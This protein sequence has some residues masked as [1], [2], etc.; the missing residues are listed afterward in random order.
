[1]Y[2]VLTSGMKSVI[3]LTQPRSGSSLLAGIL[4]RLGVTM[5]PEEDMIM[6]Q[7]KNKFGS[8]ED[9]AWL[10][11]SHNILYS[12]KRLM[13]Y[14]K[15]FDESD[16]KMEKTVNKYENEIVK[17][18]RKSEKELWGFKEAVII[19][20]LPYF[21]QHFKNPY[22]IVLHRDSESVANSQ[23]RAGK[24]KNWIPEIKMEFSYFTFWKRIGLFLRTLRATFTRG[25]IYRK[26]SFI[27]KV[28]EDGHKRITEFVKDKKY[29]WIELPEIIDY[30]EKTIE[31]I[32]NFLEITP[33]KEQKIDALRF[34]HPEL[35]TSDVNNTNND[36]INKE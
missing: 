1:M 2:N 7:H 5:G 26:K 31:K 30:P 16:G 19:Y 8:Y 3:I 33:T 11:L 10:K 18:I 29:L 22:Y 32:I 36:Q 25:F 17:L 20:I 35:I 21:H 12:A 23:K 34:V 27:S 28:T 4:H 9:Q 14:W 15:R 6:S 24:L 13:L